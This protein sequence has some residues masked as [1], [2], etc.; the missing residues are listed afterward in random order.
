[1]KWIYNIS[2]LLSALFSP[3][4][5]PTYGMLIAL[6]FSEL[7]VLPVRVKVV[8]VAVVFVLTGMTPFM[9]ISGLSTLNLVKNISLTDRSDRTIP[10]IATFIMYVAAVVYIYLVRAPWWMASFMI[11]GGVAL[12]IVAIVNR[13]WKISAHATGVGGLL[14]LTTSLACRAPEYYSLLWLLTGVL[15]ISGVVGV[16]RLVRQCHTPM[17]VYAGYLV[18]FTS[19]I[20]FSIF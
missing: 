4:M 6:N 13:W 10:Y 12:L 5:I 18:G 2:R 8:S 20:L 3:L 1:M 11:G 17:Q 14:A 15:L 7:Q 19:V 16:A 9:I